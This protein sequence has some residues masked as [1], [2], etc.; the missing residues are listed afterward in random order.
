MGIRGQTLT[1]HKVMTYPSN[2]SSLSKREY[3]FKKVI[4]KGVVQD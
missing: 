3:L 4:I 2:S 1:N